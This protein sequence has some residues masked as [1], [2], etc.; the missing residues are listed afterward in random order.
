MANRKLLANFNQTDLEVIK[1]LAE[2][3]NLT[4]NSVLSKALATQRFVSE[5]QDQGT[6]FI[7]INADGSI[8]QVYF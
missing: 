1:K 6:H 7:T 5:R 4:A 3:Y 8:T 2:R